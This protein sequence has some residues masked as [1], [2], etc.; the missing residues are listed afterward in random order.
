MVIV[1]VSIQMN[2]VARTLPTLSN[3]FSIYEACIYM[4]EHG[5]CDCFFPPFWGEYKEIV[6]TVL[7]QG[8]SVASFFYF[9]L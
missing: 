6:Y 8:F 7:L 2:A 9:L 4:A 3:C 5:D 1:A